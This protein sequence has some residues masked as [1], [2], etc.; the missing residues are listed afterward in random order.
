MPFVH[1]TPEAQAAKYAQVS[2]SIQFEGNDEDVEN[3]TVELVDEAGNVVQSVRSTKSGKYRFRNVK[4]KRRYKVRVRKKG[5]KTRE[6]DLA[7]APAAAESKAD[8]AL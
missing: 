7:P 2:G 5:K 8:F 1:D 6:A 3:A 4:A